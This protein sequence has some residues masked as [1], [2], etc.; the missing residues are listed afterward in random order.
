MEHS[1]AAGQLP[2]AH[3]SLG[4]KAP[5]RAACDTPSR[6]TQCMGRRAQQRKAA[7]LSASHIRPCQHRTAPVFGC[8]RVCDPAPAQR[9]MGGTSLGSATALSQRALRKG[10][11]SIA[12][13]VVLLR[14]IIQCECTDLQ[15]H[16][17]LMTSGAWFPQGCS[18][19]KG[20]SPHCAAGRVS[21]RALQ[22][23]V[24][25]CC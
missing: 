10:Q 12:L 11:P 21:S 19:L 13:H 23:F 20:E 4:S 24:F 18:N 8:I 3:S 16:R 2:E 5:H 25:L 17:T 1:R 9:C 7:P 14:C 6:G 15:V 22:S